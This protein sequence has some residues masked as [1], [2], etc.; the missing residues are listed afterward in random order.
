MVET[1]RRRSALA[2]FGLAARAAA[3]G[4]GDVDVMLSEIA[5]RS[6]INLRGDIGDPAFRENVARVVG[7]EPPGVPNIAIEARARHILWLGPNEWLIV[8]PD[9]EAAT[10]IAGLREG[11]GG[12]HASVVDVSESRTVINVMGPGARDFLAR[13]V[14]LDLHARVFK[15]GDCAQ[16]GMPRCNVLIHLVD[17]R[18]SFDINVLKSFA[19]YLWRWMELVGVD[20]RI[21]V[22]V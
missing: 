7:A 20:F 18:P 2:H 13:G 8:A 3:A 14:S 17:D 9:G 12:I 11:M 22:A 16:T 4:G 6:L 10:L 15:Q 21:A 19:D 1:Y 5:H